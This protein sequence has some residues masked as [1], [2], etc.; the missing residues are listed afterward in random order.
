METTTVNRSYIGIME[1]KMEATVVPWSYI[2][3]LKF[4]ISQLYKESRTIMLVIRLANPVESKL[5]SMPLSQV[6]LHY[7][8][9]F[10]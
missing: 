6:V 10:T 9:T 3:I 7:S 4:H 5:C 2:E 8:Y 1:K